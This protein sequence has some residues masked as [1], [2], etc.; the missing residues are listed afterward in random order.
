MAE[1][2]LENV[3]KRF[4]NVTA[5]ADFNLHIQDQEF[6]VF[7]GP[8]ATRAGTRWPLGLFRLVPACVP[9]AP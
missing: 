8:S 7:V 2:V 3:Y 4:G 1:V 5:V 6:M 9:T